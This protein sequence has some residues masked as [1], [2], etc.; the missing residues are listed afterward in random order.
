MK[1]LVIV[2]TVGLFLVSG[3]LV[4]AQDEPLAT[5]ETDGVLEVLNLCD[6]NFGEFVLSIPCGWSDWKQEDYA[7][8]SL[9]LTAY[10]ELLTTVDPRITFATA[11][12][13]GVLRHITIGPELVDDQIVIYR[14]TTTPYSEIAESGARVQDVIA[15]AMQIMDF[16]PIGWVTMNGRSALM[17]ISPWVSDQGEPRLNLVLLVVFP[18]QDVMAL[19]LTGASPGYYAD[20]LN[21]IVV[22]T[23]LTSLRLEGEEYDTAAVASLNSPDN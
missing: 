3:S 23:I 20:P 7:I 5:P 17:G 4:F 21:K 13:I 1:R 2:L 14:V 12:D 16:E 8:K 11:P 10:E 19:V 9:G 18:E 22:P 6:A 15:T